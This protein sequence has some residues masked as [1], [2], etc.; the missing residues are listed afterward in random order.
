MRKE[1][2]QETNEVGEMPNKNEYLTM[3]DI[4]DAIGKLKII[5]CLDQII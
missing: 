4:M 2:E 5:D 3:E 1:T